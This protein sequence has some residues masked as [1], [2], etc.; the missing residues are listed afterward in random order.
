MKVNVLQ[1][2]QISLAQSDGVTRLHEQAH[3]VIL[4]LKDPKKPVNLTVCDTHAGIVACRCKHN[5]NSNR[6][7]H[8]AR[9]DS[10]VGSRH[11]HNFACLRGCDDLCLALLQLDSSSGLCHGE[12]GH[13]QCLAALVAPLLSGV[14]LSVQGHDG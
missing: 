7:Q 6:A 8:W 4:V 5:V 14:K 12:L 3:T 1:K 9:Q 13:P 11:S 2:L 10:A